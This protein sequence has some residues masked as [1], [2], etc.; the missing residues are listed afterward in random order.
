MWNQE[1]SVE[2]PPIS[3]PI[4]GILF[5][6]SYVVEWEY[7]ITP[8]DGPEIIA[9]LPVKLLWSVNPPSDYINRILVFSGFEKY[10]RKFWTYNWMAG[11]K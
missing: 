1:T 9:L 7:P 4:M 8:P 6:N 11:V 3:N 10:L 2:V 5:P